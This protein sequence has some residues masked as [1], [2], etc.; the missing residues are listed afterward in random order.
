MT[1]PEYI[2]LD[3]I[4]TEM[5]TLQNSLLI[6]PL[7]NLAHTR[8][9][10]F[11]G[12]KD[13]TVVP[14]VMHKL[15]QLYTRFGVPVSSRFTVPAEHS[16]VTPQEGNACGY[17]GAPYIN[18]CDFDAAYDLLSTLYSRPMLPPVTPVE[19][20]LLRVDQALYVPPAYAAWTALSGINRVGYVYV[21]SRCR[22]TL[23]SS[24]AF[25]D[26]L[27]NGPATDI[28]SNNIDGDDDDD[29][30]DTDIDTYIS[31]EQDAL[32]SQYWS[33]SLLARHLSTNGTRNTNSNNSN[34]NSSSSSFSFSD[35]AP[36]QCSVH[37]ALHGCLQTLA[38]V[39]E[40]YVRE[41]GYLGYA[42]ANDIVI[43]FPQAVAVTGTNPKGCFDWWGYS[44]VNYHTKAGMQMATHMNLATTVLEAIRTG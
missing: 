18:R 44:G 31:P 21:P 9:W 41:T 3:T 14:G 16:F 36:T 29:E 11:S 27:Y 24:K 35:T 5:I 1:N 43:V 8:A 20:N 30:D 33:S 32:R 40:Q 26:R 13:T 25:T 2:N 39:G 19:N 12:T 37:V 7:S 22:T 15:N 23:M 38:D 34:I 42:E 6:D 10:L 4:T 17:K 28:N